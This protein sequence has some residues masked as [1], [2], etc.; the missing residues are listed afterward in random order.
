MI[1]QLK[2]LIKID[3]FKGFNAVFSNSTVNAHHRDLLYEISYRK[4]SREIYEFMDLRANSTPERKVEIFIKTISDGTKIKDFNTVQKL[5]DIVL[6]KKLNKGV[7]CLVKSQ[8]D[9]FLKKFMD[10]CPITSFLN[11][12][13]MIFGGFKYNRD[14]FIDYVSKKELDKSLV[15]YSGLCAVKFKRREIFST[16]LANSM[17]FNVGILDEIKNLNYEYSILM[18]GKNSQETKEEFEAFINHTIIETFAKHLQE[19]LENKKPIQM[20]S[21]KPKKMKI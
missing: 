16:L 17:K 10:T 21:V 14:E 15:F 13:K 12:K 7:D 3:D 19:E 4:Q 18:R 6:A 5:S 1:E 9:E 2:N 11:F 8:D 20:I